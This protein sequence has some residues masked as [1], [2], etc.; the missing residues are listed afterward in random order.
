MSGAAEAA[1]KAD[2][3]WNASPLAPADHPFL[4]KNKIQPHI[5]RLHDGKLIL[6]MRIAGQIA[7]L[8][9]ISPEGE[10][11]FLKGAYRHGAYCGIG[12]S[13]AEI[14]LT[15]SFLEAARLVESGGTAVICFGHMD[16]VE[17]RLREKYPA[18]VI[19]RMEDVEESGDGDSDVA[20][21]S[22]HETDDQG[23]GRGDVRSEAD[24]YDG[25]PGDDHRGRGGD[26]D[27]TLTD[28][29]LPPIEPRHPRAPIPLGYNNGSYYYL[30]MD[31][32]QVE[33]LTAT[34]HTP[35]NLRHLASEAHFWQ[36]SRF[37]GKSKVDWDAAADWLMTECKTR[38]VYS[39]ANERGRGAWL[40]RQPTGMDTPVVHLGDR[41]LVGGEPVAISK[42]ITRYVYPM[43]E[44]L[45]PDAVFVPL[46]S[47]EAARLSEICCAL[48]WENPVMGK[49]LA[50][51][52]A[53]APLC[54]CLDWRP[55]LW[56]S[57]PSGSGKTWV[58]RKIVKECLKSFAQYA[59][60]VTTEAGIRH[61]LRRD[62]LPIVFDEAE[63]ESKSQALN[64]ENILALARQASSESGGAIFKGTANQ[65]SARSYMIRSM[66]C[67]SSINIGVKYKADEARV[68]LLTLRAPRADTP[69][70]KDANRE[71][72]KRLREMVAETITEDFSSRLFAR[73][74]KL[75]PVIR[76][77]CDAFAMAAAEHFGSQRAGDQTGTLLAGAYSLHSSREITPADALTWI[78][79]HDWSGA[80]AET[81]QDHDDLLSFLLQHQLRHERAFGGSV[82]RSVAELLEYAASGDEAAEALLRRWGIRYQPR[83]RRANGAERLIPAHAEGAWFATAHASLARVL[84]GTSWSTKWGKALERVEG[85]VY[86]GRENVKFHG[87]AASKAVFIPMVMERKR[88]VEEVM[89]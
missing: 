85:A 68:S 71:H 86:S 15:E 17:D 13:R 11:K 26:S 18:A 55:H 89:Y 41:L 79:A 12:T 60:G 22:P 3:I 7:C 87:N 70:E 76:K 19:R 58:Y 43:G 61:L 80:E 6:P 50:G 59:Q 69:A 64:I 73:S 78:Q 52:I 8:Q 65:E 62:A 4:L 10:T 5:A 88:A 56:V 20:A 46:T 47:R 24:G 81:A 74:A 54:G 51:W 77:N 21:A 83:D 27:Q 39:E 72:F 23:S 82:E 35:H 32:F 29:L 16:V 2:D 49:L 14:V 66:F 84:T 67:F 42:H 33:R 44:Q 57:G 31:T 25:R 53:L 36:R 45:M 34:A 48:R 63:A 9:S 40:E 37:M 28:G 75:A 30:S 1:K 38:G